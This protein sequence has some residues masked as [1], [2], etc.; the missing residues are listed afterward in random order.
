MPRLE[1]AKATNN[2]D[3]AAALY[4]E[5]DSKGYTEP[6]KL[7]EQLNSVNANVE[8]LDV[9]IA[10]AVLIE[11]PNSTLSVDKVELGIAPEDVY[12]VAANPDVKKQIN[13]VYT[14]TVKNTSQYY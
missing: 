3:Q 14:E 4:S 9:K 12:D 1:I 11:T 8:M 5:L 6:D 13:V 7:V 10:E 2:L